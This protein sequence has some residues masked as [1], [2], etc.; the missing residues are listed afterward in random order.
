MGRGR[1]EPGLSISRGERRQEQVPLEIKSGS[2]EAS[3]FL[4]GTDRNLAMSGDAEAGET[5]DSTEIGDRH[6]A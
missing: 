2:T 6:A 3:D 4:G 5:A 1:L